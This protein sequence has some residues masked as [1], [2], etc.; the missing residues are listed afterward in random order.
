MPTEHSAAELRR[1]RDAAGSSARV[2]CI[3]N[4]Y[5][6]DDFPDVSPPLADP[7]RYRLAYVGTLWNLTDVAPL[8]DAVLEPRRGLPGTGA[9]SR[10]LVNS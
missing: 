6:P 8:V 5:D 4:G 9:A 7:D 1:V 10:D 2:D 3:Y